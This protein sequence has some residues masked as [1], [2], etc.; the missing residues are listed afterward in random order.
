MCAG[1]MIHAR[2]DRLIFAADDTKAGAA[3][4]VLD[5]LNHEALNHQM[6]LGRGLLAEESTAMLRGFFQRRRSSPTA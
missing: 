2:I 6:T 1:A 4:S 5:V 3:G